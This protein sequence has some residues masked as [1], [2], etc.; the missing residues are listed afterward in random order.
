MPATR[1]RAGHRQRHDPLHVQLANDTQVTDDAQQ[2][3][4]GA[5]RRA[6]QAVSEQH[7][8]ERGETYVPEGLSRRIL[9][10]ARQQQ[11]ELEDADGDAMDDGSAPRGDNG[12]HDAA[13]AVDDEDGD[14]EALRG[15]PDDFTGHL[16]DEI[17][18]LD[19][20]DEQA[21][22]IFMPREPRKR[23]QTLADVM[24]KMHAKRDEVSQLAAGSDDA[25]ERPAIELNPKVVLV[26][27][28]VGR[29]LARY[30]S[31]KL[32]K[33]FKVIP[34]LRNWE[35][36]VYLTKP[37]EWSPQ[38]MYQAT[39]IFSSNLNVKMAQRFFSLV[40]LPRVRDEFRASKTLNFH[41]YMALK[42]ALFKAAAFFKGILIPLCEA[43]DCTLREA[44][45]IGSVLTKMT[46]PMLHT[47]AALLKIAEMEYTGTN[48]LFLRVLLDKKYALP[49]QVV[50]ALVFH[51]IRFEN[52]PRQMPVLWHQARLAP[53]C[54]R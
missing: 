54:P 48:S 6:R 46:V 14:D 31:G 52:D 39:R 7:G 8:R 26:Y 27:E 11:D 35:E 49:Y 12:D 47:A 38:A 19:E 24:D 16:D 53:L 10:Q 32:P 15:V 51:F 22:D 18:K 2:R 4:K 40:L 13:A 45:I 17:L 33:A 50:D 25:A 1:P 3:G 34:T 29:I 20:D 43:G 9:A 30:R 23:L 5:L 21:L 42:K 41:L 44:A 36:I 37:D 28:G